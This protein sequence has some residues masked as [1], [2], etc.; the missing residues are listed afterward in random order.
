[1]HTFV[2]IASTNA[3]KIFN[4]FPRKGTI[5]PGSDADL[6]VFD[7]DFRGSISAKT[8][9][10]AVDYNAFEGWPLQGRASIVTVRGEVAAR[11]G[12]FIGRPGRGQ[13]LKRPTRP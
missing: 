2:N 7:P 12:T 6:V 8:Q 5:Q 13:F 3:A 1:L 11:D 9:A 4:L 10:S